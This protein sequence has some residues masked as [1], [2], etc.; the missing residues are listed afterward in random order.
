[1]SMREHHGEY[2]PG[3]PERLPDGERI[4][5]QGRPDSWELAKRAFHIREFALYFA[6][7]L[8]A[9]GI[10]G[11]LDGEGALAA[12]F[13]VLVIAPLA[14]VGT[15]I[16]WLLAWSMARS[17][18]YTITDRRIVLRFGVAIQIC[19][20]LPFRQIGEV[21]LRVF[22][23]G[24]GDIALSLNAPSELTYAHLW[25]HARP[26]RLA[27]PVP[28]LRALGEA[29]EVGRI[30]AQAMTEFEHAGKKYRVEGG[31]EACVS[32]GALDE[33]TPWLTSH[34]EA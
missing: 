23:S 25:P 16:V 13:S 31:A 10:V 9:R 14:F 4:L 24:H 26:W 20:N 8:S 30:L 33:V 1:M 34:A 28:M 17:A 12:A 21:G 6:L 15:A 18:I 2:S 7:F 19:A 5:W 3:L 32:S 29:A 27:K 11:V 22:K